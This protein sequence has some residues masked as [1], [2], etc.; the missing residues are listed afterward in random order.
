MS[1]YL[2]LKQKTQCP[3]C[4]AK[5]RSTINGHCANCGIQLFVNPINFQAFEDDGH[6]REWWFFHPSNGW[7]HRSQVMIEER[8]IERRIPELVTE[9]N[10]KSAEQR[11]E[12]V[13]AETRDKMRAIMPK[14]NQV[15]FGKSI[16]RLSS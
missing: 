4:R 15:G 10:T 9:K 13:K 7:M 11:V 14:R 3:R 1:E 8:P 6:S 2:L 16:T 12:E 5:R